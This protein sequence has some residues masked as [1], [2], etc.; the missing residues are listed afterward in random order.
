MKKIIILVFTFFL[1]STVLFAQ[2]KKNV[3]LT[4]DGTPVYAKEFKRVYNKNLDLVQDENQKTVDGYLDLFIDYRLKVTEAYAEKL[5]E[6]AIYKKELAE[7]Q[8]QL[9]RYYIYE[10]NVTSDLAKEAYERGM[11]EISANHILIFSKFTDSPADT[12]KAYQKIEELRERALTGEDFETLAKEN[13]QEPN[14]E[15]T[16]GDLGYFTVF[17]M[18]YPF[19]T[20]AYKT[21]KGAISN[22]LRTEFGYHIIKVKDRRKREATRSV[23]HIMIFDKEDDTRTFDPKERIDEIYQLLQQ[24]EK[25]EDLAKQ[26]SDDKGSATQGGSLRPFGKGE[27][28]SKSFEDKI[29]DIKTEGQVS[30]PFKS[31]AGWH[32]ARLDK[33]NDQPSF[34]EEKERLERRVKDGSRSKIVTAAVKNNIKKKYGFKMGAP[35][36]DFF[37]TYVNDSILRGIWKLKPITVEDNKILF[38]LG[39]QGRKTFYDLASYIASTQNRRNKFKTID[40]ALVT[41][42]EDFERD[43]LKEYYRNALEEEDENY[44]AIINEYRDGLLIFDLMKENIWNKAKLDT[45]GLQEYFEMNRSAYGWEERVEAVIVNATSQ[46]FA[47]QAS[48]LIKKG[49]DAVE[50]KKKLN[51]DTDVKAIVTYGK[52]ELSDTSLPSG[53][54]E[55]E[56]VSK[57]YSNGT[58][59][60]VVNVLGIIPPMQKELD[61]VR[62]RVL[63]DYQVKVE[64]NWI[65]GLRAKY[66][67]VLN[68]KTLKRLKKELDK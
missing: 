46:E 35:Y 22:I 14:A 67:V 61:D 5:N 50:I 21:K 40:E 30:K 27:L 60:T 9:S 37:R 45:L 39:E 66:T 17:S 15:N 12:L 3:L 16:A 10:D 44:A 13:S 2:K 20:A 4:I 49:N 6:K 41:Y 56:G 33:I 31:D 24:G 29:F 19:E 47:D 32:I 7:Y 18:V 43:A 23:S 25:F 51:T 11:E 8:E 28:R 34:E 65:Q 64:E 26:Y 62:G 36:L 1:A 57:T 68:K 53:F 38:T 55:E 63:S 48:E 58:T 52:F 54:V 59:F 42:F